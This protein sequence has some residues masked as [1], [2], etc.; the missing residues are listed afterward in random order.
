MRFNKICPRC[1]SPLF[2]GDEILEDDEGLYHEHCNEFQ[3]SFPIIKDVNED[4][5][6]ISRYHGFSK[7]GLKSNTDSYYSF[8]D[9]QE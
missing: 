4:V 6:K 9:N 2:D 1:T 3:T 7:K 8:W 5:E